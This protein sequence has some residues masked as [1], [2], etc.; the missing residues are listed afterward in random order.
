MSPAYINV[1]LPGAIA[2]FSKSNTR[3]A[4]SRLAGMVQDETQSDVFKAAALTTC[5]I[6][7]RTR[8]GLLPLY[9]SKLLNYLLERI[10]TR[11]DDNDDADHD[12]DADNSD[13]PPDLYLESARLMLNLFILNRGSMAKKVKELKR[14]PVILGLLKNETG[15]IQ[16]TAARILFYC[17]LDAEMAKY[18]IDTADIYNTM[19]PL[20][21]ESVGDD[22]SEMKEFAADNPDSEKR[23]KYV[24]EI[25]KITCNLCSH[26]RYR[27]PEECVSSSLFNRFGTILADI[28]AFGHSITQEDRKCML[29]YK[30]TFQPEWATLRRVSEKEHRVRVA[31]FNA[32]RAANQKALAMK[33]EREEREMTEEQKRTQAEE[34]K[35]IAPW[36]ALEIGKS[37]VKEKKGSGSASSAEQND[38]KSADTD[39]VSA[40]STAGVGEKE[41]Q[42]SEQEKEMAEERKKA[43][44]EEERI[45]EEREKIRKTEIEAELKEIKILMR[46]FSPPVFQYGVGKE[47]DDPTKTPM[48]AL[49][50][51]IMD[52]MV[53]ISGHLC[54]FVSANTLALKA[55]MDHLHRVLLS[56][57]R[58]APL[59]YL[60]PVI[61]TITAVAKTSPAA[62]Y[63]FK[64]R[65]FKEWAHVNAESTKISNLGMAPVGSVTERIVDLDPYSLKSRLIRHI[66]TLDFRLKQLVS[67]MIYELCSEDATDYIRLTGMGNAVG[68]LAEK[69]LPGFSKLKEQAY[70]I[71]DLIKNKKKL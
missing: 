60:G 13:A 65:I 56:V 53:Y 52:T 8:K 62:K 34:R 3:H 18:M 7:T 30:H 67:E 46:Q 68:L 45:W 64:R 20:L 21:I 35:A 11:G 61:L 29:E 39:D 6:I 42:L 41:K 40:E 10:R 54:M 22:D 31:K 69:G 14:L 19:L 26:E 24:S 9:D 71:D 50:L 55:L 33:K 59:A 2:Q 44:E 43:I 32:R 28:L 4:H 23:R 12:D 36:T 1:C 66:T 58:E 27:G 47:A 48:P 37:D 15:E 57:G 51:D 70:S 49:K 16:Y 63:Y 25:C 38:M 5:K 17:S